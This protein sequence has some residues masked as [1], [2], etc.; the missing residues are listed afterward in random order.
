[1]FNK[2]KK[3]LSYLFAEEEDLPLESRLLISSILIGFFM[4]VVGTITNLIFTTSFTA[5]LLPVLLTTFSLILYHFVRFKKIFKSTAIITAIIGILGISTI[6]VFNGGINGS[7]IM[8][9]FVILILSLVIVPNKNKSFVIFFFIAIN[10]LILLIQLYKPEVIVPFP[11][12]L[13]RWIDNLITVIYSSLITFFIIKFIHKNYTQ[14]R[15]KAEESERKV[16]ALFDQAAVGVATIDSNT[17]KYIR[18]NKKYSQIVGYSID[19]LYATDFQSITHPD[20]IND[21]FKKLELLKSGELKEFVLEKR[22][23]H[24]EGAVIWAELSV[25]PL[26]K[27]GNMPDFYIAVISD[28]SQRKK[29]EILV[30]QQNNELKKLNADKDRFISILGHDL[31]S[32]F[33]SIFGFTEILEENLENYNYE[34]TKEKLAIIKS[35]SQKTLQLLDELLDWVKSQSGKSNFEP[36]ELHFAELCNHEIENIKATLASKN[37]AINYQI[38]SNFTLWADENMLKTILRNLISNAI[39][40]TNCNGAINICA[41]EQNNCTLVT[42]S[43]NGVGIHPNDIAKLWDIKVKYTTEGT[44][45]EQGTGFGLIL[46]KEFIEKHN[47]KIW[48][49]S[50]YGKGS[51]FKFTIPLKK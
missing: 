24:K 26:W 34:E 18:V 4:S 23:L 3:A 28:I 43:D 25:S 12:E 38:E 31:R 16:Q 47:G 44:A 5:A 2:L 19:E 33:N 9:A 46:C 35:T 6:W 29:A 42:V 17:G 15:I 27:E 30:E 7:N 14:E 36:K 39:K 50:E 40:F 41:Q 49:E 11:T 37:I 10:I 48:V 1:M 21:N 13:D 45:S 22:F 8:P 20:D 32:P 51:N